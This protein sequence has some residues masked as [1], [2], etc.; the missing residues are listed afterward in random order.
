MA[1]N[2]DKLRKKKKELD[3]KMS[4]DSLFIRLE[5]GDNIFRIL[6]I[7]DDFYVEVKH[8][9]INRKL[10]VCPTTFGKKCPICQ[11]ADELDQDNI[12][13]SL[14]P[15]VRYYSIVVTKKG[16]V[17]VLGYGASVLKPLLDLLFDSSWG[18]F[19][20]RRKGYAINIRRTGEGLNTSYSVLPRPKKPIKKEKWGKWIAKAKKIDLKK[21]FKPKDYD[22]L[23]KLVSG[24]Q[25]AED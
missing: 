12:E 6:P 18:D 2:L 19:T 8:H 24:Y 21:I 23:A 15:K 7:G 16:E 1:I 25:E 4:S 14:R 3:S 9:V 13:H 5:E 10:V 22:E 20:D 11:M 17:G